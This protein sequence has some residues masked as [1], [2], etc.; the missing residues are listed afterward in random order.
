[1]MA[2]RGRRDSAM[3][4]RGMFS[5]DARVSPSENAA[6]MMPESFSRSRAFDDM[7]R[8]SYRDSVIYT[9]H[10]AGCRAMVACPGTPHPASCFALLLVLVHDL[11]VGFDH[12]VL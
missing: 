5:A 11:V 3:P 1:M 12:V 9:C 7:G 4:G 2:E 8:R 6:A 10:D